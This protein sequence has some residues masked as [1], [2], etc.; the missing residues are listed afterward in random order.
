MEFNMVVNKDK[1]IEALNWVIDRQ[2]PSVPGVP[3][4]P[5]APAAPSQ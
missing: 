3:M 1:I 4:A 5:A 2:A